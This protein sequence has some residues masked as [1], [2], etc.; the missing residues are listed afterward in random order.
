MCM[1][2]HMHMCMYMLHVN[3]PSGFSPPSLCASAL[4][5]AFHSFDRR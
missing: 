3:H 2:M 5:L 1:H 4:V